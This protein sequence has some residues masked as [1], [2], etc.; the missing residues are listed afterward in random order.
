MLENII[1]YI[2]SPVPRKLLDLGKIGKITVVDGIMSGATSYGIKIS[3]KFIMASVEMPD[4]EVMTIRN[5]TSRLMSFISKTYD[6]DFEDIEPYFGRYI[7]Y[8]YTGFINSNMTPF[9]KMRETKK[10]ERLQYL[11]DWR[12]DHKDEAKKRNDK[13]N[14]DKNI[15]LKIQDKKCAICGDPIT[16]KTSHM[17]YNTRYVTVGRIPKKIT[18]F[19]GLIDSTCKN[20]MDKIKQGYYDNSQIE[21]DKKLVKIMEFLKNHKFI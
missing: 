5:L 18:K 3:G 13:V 20:E 12:E 2:K 7:A 4:L 15:A 10:K 9:D 14:K 6:I 1:L 19:M 11:H 17:I 16:Q 21:K 8:M